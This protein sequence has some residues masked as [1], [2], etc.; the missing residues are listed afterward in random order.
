EAAARAATGEHFL[1]VKALR[2]PMAEAAV[3]RP[4]LIART[5]STRAQLVVGG[6][7]GRVA[8]RFIGLVDGLEPF[9]RVRLLAYVRMVFAGQAPVGGLDLGVASARVDAERV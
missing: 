8:Q 9:F 5:V 4:H 3:R 7:L 2:T 6:A 1:E